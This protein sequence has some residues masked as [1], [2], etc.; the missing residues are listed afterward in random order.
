M[1]GF[2]P[3]ED[4][5]DAYANR[6]HVADAQRFIDNWEVDALAFRQIWGQGPGSMKFDIPYGDKQRERFDIYYPADRPEDLQKGLFV[7]VHGGYWV[8]FDKGYWSHMAAN[9][10]GQGWAVAIPSYTLCPEANISDITAQIGTMIEKAAALVG[11]PIIL[12]G[13]SAGGHLVSRMGCTNTP[14]SDETIGRIRRIIS[15][16]GV[17]DLRPLLRLQMNSQL[18]LDESQA[19]AESPALSSPIEGL[20]IDCVVGGD[21]RPEFIRQNALLANVWTGLGAR[22]RETIVAGRHHFNIIDELSVGGQGW[23]DLD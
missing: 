21:E 3:I 11:G 10:L 8:T 2:K 15:I 20:E 18:N 12:S 5:D 9:A 13:H 17:H 19:A 6:D 14:L 16:S 22:M 7:F 1:N 4:W 23:L